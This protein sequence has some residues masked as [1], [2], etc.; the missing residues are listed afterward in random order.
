M[1]ELIIYEQPNE[2]LGKDDFTVS[3]REPGGVWQSLFVFEAKVDMHQVRST[4]MVY[5]DMEGTVEVSVHCNNRLIEQAVIRPLASQISFQIEENTLLF[6]LEQP[7]KLS[8]EINGERF[9]NLHLLP[10]P[11]RQPHLNLM[12]IM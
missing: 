1:S 10:T 6:T 5:F 8:I 11:W 2:A 7:C 12:L 4:S 9:S 3:V